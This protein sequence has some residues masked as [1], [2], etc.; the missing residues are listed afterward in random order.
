M[1]AFHRSWKFWAL[2]GASVAM[3][4]LALMVAS[5]HGGIFSVVRAGTTSTVTP[6]S[7][8]ALDIAT[9][10]RVQQLRREVALQEQDLAAFG[11]TQA[12]AQQILG[13]VLSWYQQNSTNLATLEQQRVN[14]KRALQET[15]RQINLGPADDQKVT[16]MA[17][18]RQQVTALEQQRSQM[19]QQLATQTGALLT[20]DQAAYWLA[21]RSNVGL[22]DSMRYVRNAQNAPSPAAQQADWAKVAANSQASLAGV[23]QAEAAILPPPAVLSSAATAPAISHP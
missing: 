8:S 11:C 19:I 7:A 9:Y 13:A 15:N 5:P 17:T 18:L 22:P 6:P 4:G 3:L 12:Q 14:V 21:A 23:Q 20:A 2:N 16:Q 10:S 1:G